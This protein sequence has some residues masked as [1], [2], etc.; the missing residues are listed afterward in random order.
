VSARTAR[1]K[2]RNPVSKHKT[3]QTNKQKNNK[4]WFIGKNQDPAILLLCKVTLGLEWD[5]YLVTRIH[6]CGILQNPTFSY[7]YVF[8]CVHANTY[9]CAWRS[10]MKISHVISQA[11][12][13]LFFPNT[14][15][16]TELRTWQ[17]FALVL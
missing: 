17:Y 6:P 16:H 3:K 2:Q 14:K 7:S 12:S 13:T 11:S 9:A 5:P 4:E 15:Y 10:Q 1:A 8:I